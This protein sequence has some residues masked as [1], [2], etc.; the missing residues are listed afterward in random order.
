M[1][2]IDAPTLIRL[3]EQYCDNYHQGV[4]RKGT[5]EPYSKHPRSV[6]E[7]LARNGYYDYV[8]QC[9]ALLHDVV[10]DTNVITGEIKKCFGYEVANGVYILSKNTIKRDNTIL[11]TISLTVDI[12]KLSDSELYRLRLLLARETIQRIKIADMIDNTKD[13]ESILPLSIEKKIAEANDL[14]IPLGRKVAPIMVHELEQNI[15]NYFKK[16]GRTQQIK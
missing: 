14:Y 3:A 9:V 11:A 13:L 8:T 2:N 16:V 1:H 4:F 7:I 6:R 10:E 15:E 5:N 12:S